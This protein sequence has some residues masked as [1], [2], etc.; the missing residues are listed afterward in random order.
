MGR[1]PTVDGRVTVTV[2]EASSVRH[3]SA[4]RHVCWVV[5]DEATYIDMAEAFLAQGRADRRKTVAF[6][7]EGSDVLR[8]LAATALMSVDPRTAFLDDGPLQ[9]DTMFT[10]FRAQTAQARREGYTGLCLVADMDWLLPMRADIEAVVRFEL[11][12]DQV[13]GE[14]GAVVVCAYRRSSFDS[15]A[16][17]GV[18]AVHPESLGDAEPPQFRFLSQGP[19][20]WRL[21]GEVDL[22]VAPAFE[23][24]FQ[25]AAAQGRC[26][27]DVDE[28]HFVDVAGMRAMASV[29]R[30]VDERILL[31]GAAA[32]LRRTW[33]LLHFHELAPH[34][35]LTA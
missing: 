9:P 33:R 5:D 19:G 4:A 28:L 2:T 30:D 22:A 25:A 18:M 12:L 15:A 20:T 7:P 21:S 31:R 16:I 13:V 27:V 26:L 8:A 6:G 11:L 29:G 14:L 10:M 35:E 34:I 23:A 3:P 32:A 17:E 24:A 1:A